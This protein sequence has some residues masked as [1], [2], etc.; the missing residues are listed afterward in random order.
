MADQGFATFLTVFASL[1][2][3]FVN[4]GLIRFVRRFTA[5]EMHQTITKINVSVALKLSIARFLN[6][7]IILVL[8]NENTK[9]WF[10]GGSLAYDATILMVS[11]AF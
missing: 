3:L 11:G 4:D 9:R 7:S 10:E 5:F 1:T 6:Q 8:V 2:I